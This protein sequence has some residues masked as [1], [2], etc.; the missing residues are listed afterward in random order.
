VRLVPIPPAPPPGKWQLQ[1][2]RILVTGGTG[3]LGKTL[4]R[5]ILSGEWGKPKQVRV[6]SRDEAKQHVMRAEFAELAEQDA[7]L[8][9]RSI[10][11]SDGPLQFVIGDVRDVASLRRAL[12]GVQVVFNAAALKQVPS[13]EYYPWEA[14]QTNIGGA[15]ALVQ[16]VLE[17][18]MRPEVVVGVSTDKACK[19]VN[20]MGMTKAIQERLFQQANML[21]PDVK[22]VCVRYGNVLASRGSV[23]P[24]FHHQILN[25]GPVTVT[26]PRMTRFFLT[27]DGAVDTIMAAV[28]HGEP[29]DTWIPRAPSANILDLANELTLSNKVEVSVTEIR[30]GEKL[31]EELVSVEEASR[32]LT[33]KDGSHFVIRSILPEV[34]PEPTGEEAWGDRAFSSGN[35]DHLLSSGQLRDLLEKHDLLAPQPLGQEVLR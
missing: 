15:N 7:G 14:V 26:D 3:S 35:P 32:A 5:R 22:F 13:C 18:S 17:S 1:G 27:L 10:S 31:H 16:A 23:I 4:V 34:R 2:K 8:L 24:L 6:F 11:G 29:G 12:A 30:P 25:G 33:S 19:P 20:V 9:Y 28:I 21:A